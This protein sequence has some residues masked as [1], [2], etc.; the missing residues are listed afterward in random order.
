MAALALAGVGALYLTYKTLSYF[1]AKAYETKV[2]EV[3]AKPLSTVT[4][5]DM[6]ANLYLLSQQAFD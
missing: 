2:V 3:D 1:R 6:L 4:D 5:A